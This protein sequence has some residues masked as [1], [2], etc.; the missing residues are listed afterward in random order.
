MAA[1][2]LV[3]PTQ[4]EP[5]RLQSQHSILPARAFNANRWRC[6]TRQFLSQVW[7]L[8]IP[9]GGLKLQGEGKKF[10]RFSLTP[11]SEIFNNSLLGKYGL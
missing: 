3:P 2:A 7:D 11:I 10:H 9:S 4:Q 5:H 1:L 8:F 6:A